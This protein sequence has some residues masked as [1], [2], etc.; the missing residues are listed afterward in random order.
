VLDRVIAAR[1]AALVV[2]AAELPEADRDA[3]HA[4][5]LPIVERLPSP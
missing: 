4:A 3:L 2:F 5:L 1:E